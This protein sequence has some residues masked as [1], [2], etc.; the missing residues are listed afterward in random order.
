MIQLTLGASMDGQAWIVQNAYPWLDVSMENAQTVHRLVIVI[1][2]G[3]DH[4]AMLQFASNI[5]LFCILYYIYLGLHI[6]SEK[7]MELCYIQW[8]L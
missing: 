2:D 7:Y 3:K 5:P 6:A 8:H 4:Y 1:Q